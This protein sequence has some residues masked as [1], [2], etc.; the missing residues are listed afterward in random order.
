MIEPQDDVIKL[1][2]SLCRDNPAVEG[3]KADAGSEPG[4]FVQAIRADL[5][6]S[7]FILTEDAALIQ[8]RE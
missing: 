8:G 7:S 1:M 3:A 6:A 4:Q 2:E 5:A